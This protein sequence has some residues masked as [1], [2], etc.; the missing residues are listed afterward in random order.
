V[1]GGYYVDSDNVA[2]G[3]TRS[4]SGTITPYNVT[5]AGTSAGEGTTAFAMD[6]GGVLI[7]FYI[8]ST[9]TYVGY[10]RSSAGKF[11]TFS[12]GD[13]TETYV[14]D[15]NTALTTCGYFENASG[16]TEGFSR[17][18]AG[19]VTDLVDPNAGTAVGAGT[20]PYAMNTAGTIVGTYLTN[21]LNYGAFSWTP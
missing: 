1:I 11:T 3:F 12:I 4:A 9:G 16:P 17:T 19:V 6:A 21:G 13:A 7:G 20:I 8:S 10:E 2:H 15:V 5:G 18:K 14:N